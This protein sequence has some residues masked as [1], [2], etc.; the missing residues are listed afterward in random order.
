[1]QTINTVFTETKIKLCASRNTRDDNY[2]DWYVPVF[3]PHCTLS[4]TI[5]DLHN[6]SKKICCSS[7]Q[8]FTRKRI[9]S[10]KNILY[11]R[12]I[13]VFH[14]KYVVK[15]QEKNILVSKAH[16]VSVRSRFCPIRLVPP[17][18]KQS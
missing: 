10:H 4:L 3:F 8:T 5:P 12:N 6:A 16:H 11:P 14:E 9:A 15:K 13:R 2:I 17:R 1:M 18:D 7:A